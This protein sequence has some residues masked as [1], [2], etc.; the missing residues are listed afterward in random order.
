M[1]ALLALGDEGD[2]E[3]DE[4]QGLDECGAEDEDSEQAALHLR[5]TGDGGGGTKRREADADTGADN[6]KTIT[7]CSHDS[8][9]V[10][11][12]GRGDQ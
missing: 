9:F 10:V 7:N 12:P 5:L 2:D 4:G 8:S 6:T 3:A 11:R 1:S